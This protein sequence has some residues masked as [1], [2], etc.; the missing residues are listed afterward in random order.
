M[1]ADAPTLG[2]SLDITNLSHS[3]TKSPSSPVFSS[4]N[5]N[6][7][8]GDFVALLGESGCGKSTLL[9]YMAGFITPTKGR[10]ELSPGVSSDATKKISYVFQ[11][12]ELLPWRTTYDNVLLPLQLSN[13]T[14]GA[15]SR[16]REVLSR[17]GLAKAGRLY[18]AELSGGMKM[19][20]SLARA[21]VTTPRLLLM[22][23][24]FSALDER[25][26]EQL[27]L[28]IRSLW[29]QDR[30]TVVFVTH[31]IVEALFLANRIVVLGGQP[32]RILKDLRVPFGQAERKS[33][34][35]RQNEFQILYETL[36][37][38]LEGASS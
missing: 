22:D 29:N 37:K 32:A 14:K 16:V 4:L 35:R 24:P 9:N 5:L 19:R 18:P 20:A 15:K 3:Y 30:I 26:R 28:D 21:L 1:S 6:I 27:D 25:T 11:D 7:A 17:V 36:S 31:S 12:A 23:E 8:A 38:T 34:L 2:L 33:S 13:D 10:I